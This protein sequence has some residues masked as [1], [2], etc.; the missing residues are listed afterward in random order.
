MA[1][2]LDVASGFVI[3]QL[4]ANSF[5]EPLFMQLIEIQHV[6]AVPGRF[7]CDQ[8][9]KGYSEVAVSS[10]PGATHHL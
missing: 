6:V 9:G 3:N 8:C 1:D 2:R 7:E 4:V 10:A 5:G